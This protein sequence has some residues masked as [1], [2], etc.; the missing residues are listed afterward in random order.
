MWLP[1]ALRR[2]R[3]SFRNLRDRPAKS[4]TAY[5]CTDPHCPLWSAH[6]P[7]QMMVSSPGN[8]QVPIDVKALRHEQAKA[9]AQFHDR[10]PVISAAHDWEA[11]ARFEGLFPAPTDTSVSALGSGPAPFAHRRDEG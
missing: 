8:G 9:M 2:L 10:L 11:D 4:S 7:S 1:S 6:P 5:R 3:K